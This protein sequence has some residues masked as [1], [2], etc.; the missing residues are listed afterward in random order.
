MKR[1]DRPVPFPWPSS[2][3]R[4]EFKRLR[5]LGHT[6]FWA[7]QL[8]RQANH[9]AR[10]FPLK[11][12]KCLAYARTTGKPCQAP[13]GL[14]GRCKLHSGRA[15]GPRTPEGKA[16]ALACI[17]QKPFS[18]KRTP[19]KRGTIKLESL[20]ERPRASWRAKSASSR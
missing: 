5:E 4:A 16:K 7:R 12:E 8:I 3:Y 11:G 1:S 19:G 15:T 17:G 20:I 9:K 13:A 18:L 2:A 14:N 10:M 6:A